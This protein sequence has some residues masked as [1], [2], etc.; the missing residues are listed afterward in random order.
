MKQAEGPVI[1]AGDLNTDFERDSLNKDVFE[2]L[3][4]KYEG[5][6]MINDRPTFIRGDV[7]TKIDHATIYDKSQSVR[8]TRHEVLSDAISD[9]R[10]LRTDF[11]T[12][13][14]SK[15]TEQGNRVRWDRLC[16]HK[17]K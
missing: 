6:R 7:E 14:L 2:D 10:P 15:A 1:M 13:N 12:D 5:I 4:F 17:R 9:H 16:C 3:E 11:D 8:A